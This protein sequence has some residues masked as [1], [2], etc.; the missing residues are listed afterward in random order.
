[1]AKAKPKKKTASEKKKEASDAKLKKLQESSEVPV[2]TPSESDTQNGQIAL[3][4]SLADKWAK[5]PVETID[6]NSIVF[7]DRYRKNPGDLHGLAK[8]I[9]E[10]GMLQ[11]IGVYKKGKDE[12]MLVCGGRRV[13]AIRDILKLP[14]V[15][16]VVFDP[17]VQGED[18]REIRYLQMEMEENT[19]REQPSYSEALERGNM[20]SRLLGKAAPGTRSQTKR[21]IVSKAT[22]FSHET[23]RKAEIVFNA[24]QKKDAPPEIKELATKLDTGEIRP[25]KAYQKVLESEAAELD[26]AGIPIH[27]KM[28]DAFVTRLV[29]ENLIAELKSAN[30][31]VMTICESDGG[32]RLAM[33]TSTG[34]LKTRQLDG[35]DKTFS[36]GIADLITALG[37]TIPFAQCPPCAEKH[38]EL[39]KSD[40]KCE[41]CHGSGHI[42]KGVWDNLEKAGDKSVAAIQ[43]IGKDAQKE[44]AV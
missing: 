25:D 11:P 38:G 5:W 15:K 20:I 28:K 6:V 41:T 14:T 23:R 34:L 22:G 35:A 2:E 7:G 30:K 19:Q 24:A 16:A 4:Q 33:L 12:Y 13:M 44:Q 1:M 42:S 43:K 9:N 10:F 27:K 36:K 32:E 17:D 26:G 18:A 39:G 3:N 31:K 8:S 29:F 40:K 21:D 37:E